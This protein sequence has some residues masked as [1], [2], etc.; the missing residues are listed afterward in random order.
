MIP[1]TPPPFPF[2]LSME[3]FHVALVRSQLA[4]VYSGISIR[5]IDMSH[6]LYVDDVV[7]MAD[8]DQKI[9]IHIVHILRC[10]LWLKILKSTYSRASCMMSEF[11]LIKS[12][13][14]FIVWVVFWLPFLS[15]I[16]E[17]LSVRI[18]LELRLGLS[19]WIGSWVDWQDGRQDA[20]L[21]VFILL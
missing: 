16:W 5:G 11:V 21:L 18:W 6:L 2:V 9:G 14:F 7:L 17:C 15:S 8:W 3:G 13:L 19:L 1:Y 12:L 10:F 4:N 20:F